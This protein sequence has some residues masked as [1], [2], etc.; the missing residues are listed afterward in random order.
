MLKEERELRE[1]Y[2]SFVPRFMKVKLAN[3][4]TALIAAVRE[5][6]IRIMQANCSAVEGE[7]REECDR[8]EAAIR[9]RKG[10]K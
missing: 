9:S 10:R 8:N 2:S 1:M 5:D 3:R 7:T 6:D 4:I